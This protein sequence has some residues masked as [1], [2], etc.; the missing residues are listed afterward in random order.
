VS[1]SERGAIAGRAG[2]VGA[3]TLVSRVLGL[4][5]DLVLA[6]FFPRA[7][8][9]LFFV[10]FTIPNALRQLLAEGALAS[11]F[12]PVLAKVEEEEGKAAAEAFYAK[13]RGA[14][15]VVLAIVCV[16]G[17]AAAPWLCELFAAGFHARPGAFERTVA[18]TR[19][20][21]PYLFFM[22]LAA[23]GA[24]ALQ[25]R[26]LFGVAAFA[27]ALLNVAMIMCAIALAPVLGR[28]GVDPLYALAIGAL[29]G[30]A[31][32]VWAQMPDLRRAG[33]TQRLRIDFSD[34]HLRDVVR[35]IAPMTLG[36][37]IYEV[38]LVLSRRFLSQ[39]GEGANSWFYYAQR[40]CDF[41]QGIFALALATATLPS[42]A[43]LV[44]RGDRKEV[45]ETAAHAFRLALFVGI[46]ASALLFALARPL[47]IAVFA[48]GAFDQVSVD[49]TAAA[50]MVQG[51]GVVFV[52][53]V[54]QLVPLY[55]ALGDTK[56]PVWISGVDLCA[57]IAIALLTRGPLGHVGVSW[58]VTGSSLVQ[59]ALLMMLLRTRLPELRWSMIGKTVVTVTVASAV[60]GALGY[61]AARALPIGKLVP[62]IAGGTIF[63]VGFVI[64]CRVLRNDELAEIGAGLSRRLRSTK[65]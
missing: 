29:I 53:M 18:L 39:A 54:R 24:G 65:K 6:A 20:V 30:G 38:D 42:L 2:I 60:A 51:L 28:H 41:P 32:Q 56:T 59:M 55:Y 45:A 1:K 10:A 16:L 13:L 23:I 46:P 19:A 33:F 58:A 36:L 31:L 22:G 57:F 43:K 3:G 26:K 50:L 21:F 4:G 27:P 12:V 7:A 62:A 47:V 61:F 14:M 9:D 64:V 49:G 8:T 52:A 17:V 5:R 40:L 15:W 48:R 11:A 63:V 37:M 25:T 35:R 34:P 44:A